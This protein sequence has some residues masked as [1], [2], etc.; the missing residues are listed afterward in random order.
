MKRRDTEL[1]DI[2]NKDTGETV[3]QVCDYELDVSSP[4]FM[5]DPVRWAVFTIHFK[6]FDLNI[7]T[8]P[9]CKKIGQAEILNGYRHRILQGRDE[10]YH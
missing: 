10:R 4:S 9:E 6:E 3:C 8:C 2:G 1:H 5:N 7:T